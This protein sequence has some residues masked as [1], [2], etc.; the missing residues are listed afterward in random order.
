[1]T[2]FRF[3]GDSRTFVGVGIGVAVFLSIPVVDESVVDIDS[4]EQEHRVGRFLE[5]D[6]IDIGL[7]GCCIGSDH[8]GS[9]TGSNRSSN[10]YLLCVI[11]RNS[12]DSRDST[13]EDIDVVQ[14]LRIPAV[15]SSTVELQVLK[16]SVLGLEDD[17]SHLVL[18]GCLFILCGHEVGIDA[19]LLGRYDVLSVAGNSLHFRSGTTGGQRSCVL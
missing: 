9:L 4:I 12:G 18:A 11:I 10:G 1:M 3:V 2:G 17:D 19:V 15:D 16:V 8:D 14:I 6:G 5:L 7:V 13:V